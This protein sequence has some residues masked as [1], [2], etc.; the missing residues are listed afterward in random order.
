MPK[1][2]KY[3]TTTPSGSLRKGNMSI[4]P[5]YFDYGIS[6]YSAIEPPASGYTIYLNKGSNGPSIYCPT[7]ETELI[8]LFDLIY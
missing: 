6:F 5:G 3:S 8:F 7:N 2:V 4:G 1:V